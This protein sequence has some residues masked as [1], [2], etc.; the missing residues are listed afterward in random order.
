MSKAGNYTMPVDI[1]GTGIGARTDGNVV[2][3]NDMLM[4]GNAWRLSNGIPAYQ[5]QA[6]LNSK[7]L[8]DYIEAASAEWGL[9]K[10]RLMYT[11]GAAKKGRRTYAHIS[12]AVLLAEQMSPAFHAKIHRVFIEGKLLEFRR[13]GGTEFIDL[14]AAI[15]AHLPGRED[16]DSDKGVFITVAKKLRAKILGDGA[17]ADGWSRA[18]VEQTHKRYDFENKLVT[19]LRMGLVRDFGHLKE[20]IEKL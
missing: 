19:F 2:C 4:A 5:L 13:L 18:S 7:T 10:D 12:V 1:F 16:K 15:D 9:P 8:E 3:L 11:E 17:E 14:N 6:F 20:L